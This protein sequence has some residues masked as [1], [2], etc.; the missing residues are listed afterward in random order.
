MDPAIAVYR[1]NGL[2]ES[3]TRLP[4]LS[5]EGAIVMERILSVARRCA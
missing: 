3:S 5:M 1:R 2:A 4:T